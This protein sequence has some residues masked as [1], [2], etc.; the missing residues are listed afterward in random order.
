MRYT[1]KPVTIEAIRF[2]GLTDFGDPQFDTAPT[3]GIVPDWLMEAIAAPEGEDGSV[4]VDRSGSKPMLVHTFLFNY[5]GELTPLT[6][7]IPEGD[8]IT[9]RSGNIG[10]C[11]PDIFE[12]TYDVA[13][14]EG[15]RDAVADPTLAAIHDTG[16]RA[17]SDAI[18]ET[19]VSHPSDLPNG[20]V[21]RLRLAVMDAVGE[22]QEYVCATNEP[23]AF[24]IGE[25]FTKP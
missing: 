22:V 9:R 25:G 19:D 3:G 17:L 5:D 16:L 10:I 1:K 15:E 24:V 4:W 7:G 11:G 21:N 2:I 23:T 13:K 12:A 6:D 20:S 14:V 18:V 8:W